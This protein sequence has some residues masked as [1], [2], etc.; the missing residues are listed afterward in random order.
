MG[1]QSTKAPSLATRLNLD[2]AGPQRAQVT[3]AWSPALQYVLPTGAQQGLCERGHGGNGPGVPSKWSRT[4]M[5]VPGD[6]RRGS[7][8]PHCQDPDR[9]WKK[10]ARPPTP[11]GPRQGCTGP[12]VFLLEA[13]V[14]L[15]SPT[16]AA[17]GSSIAHNS[18]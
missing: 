2:P 15:S 8:P 7:G 18:Y 11:S 12:S 4:T 1:G 5:S 10:G 16:T 14:F 17:Q 3:G 9:G 6:G 13:A